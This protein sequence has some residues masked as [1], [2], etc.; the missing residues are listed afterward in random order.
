MLW[1]FCIQIK[2]ISLSVTQWHFPLWKWITKTPQNLPFPLPDVDP[3]LIQQCLGPLHAPPQTT[4]PTIEALS[5]MCAIK[6]PLDT[7]RTPNV[8]PKVPLSVDRSAN[9][10]TC[11]IP[12]H[13][14]PMMPNGIGIRSAIFP[15]CTGQTDRWFTGKFDDYRLLRSE[16]DAAS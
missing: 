13:V 1:S 5:H 15:Q 10:T 3:H 12:G 16:S 2:N 4:A 8:L 14:R 11:L 7:R 6:S 9:P